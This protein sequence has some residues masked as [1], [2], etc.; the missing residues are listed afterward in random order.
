MATAVQKTG[1]T[2]EALRNR[3][4]RIYFIGQLASRWVKK[5]HLNQARSTQPCGSSRIR[6]HPTPHDD[7]P[8]PLD[9]R[10]SWG[11]V[12]A[13]RALDGCGGQ[14]SRPIQYN[15]PLNVQPNLLKKDNSNV[16]AAAPGHPLA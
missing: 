11:E 6:S 3:N 5:P 16:I 13:V 9:G 8:G 15:L 10:W 7:R 2:F 1:G 14:L 12:F 4:F